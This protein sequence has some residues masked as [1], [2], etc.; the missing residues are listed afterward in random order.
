MYPF[1][2]TSQ[3]FM[4]YCPGVYY[5]D[6]VVWATNSNI[7]IK[8]NDNVTFGWKR[9]WVRGMTL[10]VHSSDS[11]RIC[12]CYLFNPSMSVNPAKSCT[13]IYF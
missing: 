6:N 5:L 7:K 8:K 3:S 11:G 10:V 9:G 4:G 2:D 1:N 13:F 12:I